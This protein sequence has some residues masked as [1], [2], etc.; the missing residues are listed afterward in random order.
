MTAFARPDWVPRVP[1]GMRILIAGASGGLGR[2]LVQM[3]LEA[4]DCVIGAHGATKA[5][6]I[7][8]RRVIPLKKVFSTVHV[9]TTEVAGVQPGQETFVILATD[10]PF[11]ASDWLPGHDPIYTGSVLTPANIEELEKKCNRRVLTD[12][13]APVENLMEPLVR[14][15][16]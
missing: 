3:L 15:R 12:N 7:K 11:D 8:D 13:N 2:A 4:S 9:F 1:P 14:K 6:K 5:S 10:A 16:R